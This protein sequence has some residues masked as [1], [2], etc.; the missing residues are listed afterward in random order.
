MTV[1]GLSLAAGIGAMI[2]FTLL[3]ILP[4]GHYLTGV[5]W[6]NVL[7]T[8]LL[9]ILFAN[10]ALNVYNSILSVG[11][12]GGLTTFSTMMTQS[13]RRTRGYQC[14]YLFGQIT[15][16]IVAFGLGAQI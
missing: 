8:F 13:A 7:G 2:R 4:E 5:F 3:Q 11:L 14:L 9:G 1:I 6:V 16:G 10:H 12:L 15:A